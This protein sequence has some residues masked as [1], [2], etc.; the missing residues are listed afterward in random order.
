MDKKFRSLLFL[1]WSLFFVDFWWF[2]F[3]WGVVLMLVK[4]KMCE[5]D[6]LENG[7]IVLGFKMFWYIVFLLL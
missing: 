1:Y 2:W 5:K 3:I 7:L 6:D 4:F